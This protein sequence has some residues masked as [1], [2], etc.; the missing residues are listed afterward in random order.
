MIRVVI[1]DD[2]EVV[3]M[4]LRSYLETEPDILVVGEAANGQDAV[5]AV[6]QTDADVV[7]MDLIMPVMSGIEATVAIQAAQ[8][9][10]R[11]VILTSSLDDERMIQALRAGALSYILK[12]T[13]AQNVV[14]AIRAAAKGT[15]VLD[16]QVQQRLVGE[17]QSGGTPKPWEDLTDRE[18]DVLQGIASGK[19]NQ[20]IA[21]SLGIGIK[22]VKTH[23][24]N[25]FMK[26]GVLDRTQ[27]AIF[28]I[29][30]GLD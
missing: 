14:A 2:H 29:K 6:R 10:A 12:T 23:V 16:P 25:I 20:E 17:L 27:A 13:P 18:H 15:S 9:T 7:L 19:N 28:A 4:G 8:L 21:D 3:R 30:H 5:E 11:V 26:L 1:V 22:T 24:S